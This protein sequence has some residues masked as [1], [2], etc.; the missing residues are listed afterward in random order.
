M[1]NNLDDNTKKLVYQLFFDTGNVINLL[2]TTEKV[3]L[4][5]IRQGVNEMLDYEARTQARVKNAEFEMA[6]KY[7][8]NAKKENPGASY[9]KI[10]AK[11]KKIF[12]FGE[13]LEQE[14]LQTYHS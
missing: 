13:A 2:E 9:E 4:T 1:K 3:N 14:L 11:A 8:I 7:I 10:I 5:K 6:E 12:E